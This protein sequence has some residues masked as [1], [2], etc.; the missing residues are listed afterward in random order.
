MQEFDEKIILKEFRLWR[1]IQ[2]GEFFVIGNDCSQGG[3]DSNTGA[4]LSK[5]K[6]DFP[7]TYRR[8][9]VAN[10]MT[11][12]VFPVLEWLFDITGV[13]PVIAFERNNG[14]ASEMDRLNKLNIKHKYEIYVMKRKGFTSEVDEETKKLGWVTDASTRPDLVKD[15][16]YAFDNKLVKI[17]DPEFIEEHKTFVINASGKPEA[18]KGFHDDCVFSPA[19]AWQLY[20][21]EE[22]PASDEDLSD[23]VSQL[24]SNNLFKGGYR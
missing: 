5:S 23:L 20:Q 22:P 14:G 13:K 10:D 1:K 9:G 19:I 16:K 21:T 7:I 18:A 6:L 8:Q 3:S 24:P 15:W 2:R 12:D 11:D 17:Y 4:F